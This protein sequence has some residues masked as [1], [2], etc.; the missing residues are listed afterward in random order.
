MLSTQCKFVL[1]KIGANLDKEHHVFYLLSLIQIFKELYPEYFKINPLGCKKEYSLEELLGLNTWGDWNNH[2]SCRDKAQLCRNND[3]SVQVLISGQPS[4]STINNF[5]NDESL[6]INAFDDFIVEFCT[7]CGLISGTEFVT[8]GTFYDSYSN[9]FK[10]LYPDEIYYVKDFL[11]DTSKHMDD[12]ALL[13][14]YFYDEGE[15]CDELTT[16]LKELKDNLNIHGIRLIVRALK[17]NKEYK[18]VMDNLDNMILNITKENIQ[19]SIVDPDAHL[20]YD[21]DHQKGF[22]YNYQETTDTKYGIIV[23]HY[24]T[25]NP[26]DKKEINKIN[27]RLINIFGDNG[28]SLGVDN[29]YWNIKLLIKIIQ[30]TNTKVV[31]PDKKSATNTKD[32]IIQDNKSNKRYN[33][34]VENKKN[35]K[36][37]RTFIE[38]KEFIYH[39]NKDSYECPKTGNYLEHKNTVIK[40]NNIQY[41]QYWTNEC[42]KCPYHD[43]CTSQS[44]RI[45]EDVNEPEINYINELFNSLHG[46][47]F[48]PKRG[49]YA[50]GNFGTL[51]EARNF[52]GIKVRG[53]QKVDNQLTRTVIIHNIKKIEKHIHLEVLEKVLKY[54]EKEKTHQR[55]SIKILQELKG[56]F[57]EENDTIIDVNI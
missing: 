10:G 4:K 22:H 33:E 26:N 3:E 39:P 43:K 47:N 46:Q 34:Y 50:E 53:Q 52:R 17:D 2:E 56:K 31:I 1:T 37:C 15:A 48:Y 14:S 57:I 28:F 19:V 36:K 41:R 30:E 9:D 20:M 55:G 24:I 42:K 25:K 5:N 38:R 35:N 6:L 27:T 40:D 23:D 49:S 45:L 29:G 13:Y 7:V 32:K 54:I 8:D 51:T 16:L 44:K 11:R 18:K 12:Y 21:K